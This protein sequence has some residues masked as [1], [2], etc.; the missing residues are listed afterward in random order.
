[1]VAYSLL[2]AYPI[3][4]LPSTSEN[5]SG[6]MEGRGIEIYIVNI[7]NVVR[8]I[9]KSQLVLLVDEHSCYS[10]ESESVSC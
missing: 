4:C 1:M 7:G 8:F 9:P 3:I 6:G 10:D 2:L 5:Q